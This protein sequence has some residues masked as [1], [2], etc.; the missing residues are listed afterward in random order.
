VVVSAAVAGGLTWW[1]T[2]RRGDDDEEDPEAVLPPP[3]D[4]AMIHV[5]ES[6]PVEEQPG[7]GKNAGSCVLVL[8]VVGDPLQGAKSKGKAEEGGGVMSEEQGEGLGFCALASRHWS[9]F[10][11]TVFYFSP[12]QGRRKGRK[13]EE[14]GGVLSI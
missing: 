14:G 6:P 12:P 8:A 7:S 9:I 5:G 11:A 3:T 4:S 2:T 10:L 13:E 1:I